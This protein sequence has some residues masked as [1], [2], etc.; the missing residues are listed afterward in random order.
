MINKIIVE[1]Y[2]KIEDDYGTF[3]RTFTTLND[4]MDFIE[5]KEKCYSFKIKVFRNNG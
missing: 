3:T 5:Q 1:Y 4:A 2:V